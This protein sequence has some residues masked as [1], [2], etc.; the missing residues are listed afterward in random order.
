MA[1]P[2]EAKRQNKQTKI[3][4]MVLPMSGIRPKINT[5]PARAATL[6]DTF[7]IEVPIS[8]ATDAKLA[9]SKATS[10]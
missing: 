5:I 7:A 2:A 9:A 8:R 6:T 10:S 4:A 1:R 3:A